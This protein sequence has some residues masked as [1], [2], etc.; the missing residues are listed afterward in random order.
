MVLAEMCSEVVGSKRMTF[1][2]VLPNV[3]VSGVVGGYEALKVQEHTKRHIPISHPSSTGEILV[4]REPGDFI[5][6]HQVPDDGCHVHIVADNQPS[7]SDLALC[8]DS[9]Q[10]YLGRMT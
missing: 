6:R 4:R 3:Y 5:T 1:P 7:G 9:Q 2:C 8:I 10:L